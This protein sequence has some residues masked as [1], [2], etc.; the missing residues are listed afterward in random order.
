MAEGR[1]FYNKQKL[2]SG[3]IERENKADIKP[4]NR[5]DMKLLLIGNRTQKNKYGMK[6]EKKSYM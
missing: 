3:H 5:A 2:D 4:E 6:E 1:S